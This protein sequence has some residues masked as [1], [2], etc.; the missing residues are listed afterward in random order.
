MIEPETNITSLF[1]LRIDKLKGKCI[2]RWVLVILICIVSVFSVVGQATGDYRS[3]DGGPWNDLTNW[4]RYNGGAWIQPTAVEGYPAQFGSPSRIDINNNI[5]LNVHLAN[6]VNPRI[7]NLYINSGTLQL[8]TYNFTVNGITNI[9]GTLS[10]NSNSGTDAFIGKVTLN[11]T[12]IWNTIIVTTNNLLQFNNG[13]QNDN[14]NALSFQAGFARFMT[15]NQTLSGAG[16]LLF[17]GAV[18]IGDIDVTNLN[19]STVTITGT[20]DRNAGGENPVLINGNGSTLVYNSATVP[21]NLEGT[22]IAATATNTVT[23]GSGVGQAIY[24]K[25]GSNTYH[26]LV[27]AGGGTKTL[28]GNIVVNG[29]LTIGAG[30]T[31]NV[32]GSNYSIN[33][34]GNWINQGSEGQPCGRIS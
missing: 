29:N 16:A 9:S 23:Y 15:N 18:R 14:T 22:L 12:G 31:L 4:Q 10:D 7:N 2:W 34:S 19:T 30:T 26:H 6:T 3:V 21:F 5:T 13:I 8:S 28:Q 25:A 24:A 17:N 32:T 20:L 11:I 1:K 27:T 33:L